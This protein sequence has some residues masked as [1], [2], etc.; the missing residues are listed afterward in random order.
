MIRDVHPGSGSRIWILGF[1]PIPDPGVKKAPYPVPDPQ[2]CQ[3]LWTLDQF[4]CCLPA[5]ADYK[6]EIFWNK[7]TFLIIKKDLMLST[8]AIVL[9]SNL[10]GSALIIN[11]SWRIRIPE[12]WRIALSFLPPKKYSWFKSL[13]I[14]WRAWG[15][16][17]TSKLSF[18]KSFLSVVCSVADP[19]S[20]A[21]LTPGSG[22]RNRVFPD[23]GSRIPDPKPIFLRAYSSDN[24]LSKKFYNS[25]KMGPDFFLKHF[26]N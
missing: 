4:C 25:L 14:L 22:I 12:G 18:S 5:P 8:N 20:G 16:F 7:K 9:V 13:A 1:L 10:H 15:F 3:F 6:K 26:K 19:G 17:V 23:P 2:H 21:F 24:F 11:L